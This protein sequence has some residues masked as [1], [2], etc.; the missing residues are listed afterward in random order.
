MRL[1]LFYFT[2]EVRESLTPD[3]F[4]LAF[5]SVNL[6]LRSGFG[7]NFLLMPGRS[8]VKLFD[9]WESQWFFLRASRT[10]LQHTGDLPRHSGVG[11]LK[12]APHPGEPRSTDLWKVIKIKEVSAERSFCDLMEEIVMAGRFMMRSRPRSELGIPRAFRPPQ[13]VIA[14]TFSEER[15]ARWAVQQIGPYGVLEHRGYETKISGGGC[16]NIIAKCFGKM[17]PWTRETGLR[18]RSDS[19]VELSTGASGAGVPVFSIGR[20]RLEVEAPTSGARVAVP[21]VPEGEPSTQARDGELPT[22]ED[23]VRDPLVTLELVR[24]LVE[25]LVEGTPQDSGGGAFRRFGRGDF[26]VYSCLERVGF[27]E[28]AAREAV[29]AELSRVSAE[30][31]AM[32]TKARLV[33]EHQAD[34]I[35]KTR[36]VEEDLVVANLDRE[37]ARAEAASLKVELAA[38]S[39]GPMLAP[40]AR[41]LRIVVPRWFR[42]YLL[43]P[44]RFGRR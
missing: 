30:L 32:E 14:P 5:G 36:R 26:Q 12:E 25:A 19:L 29:E 1:L 17:W 27:G 10:R 4:T 15:A 44:P 7:D 24:G 41:L 35:A 9:K 23:G 20:E 33:E 21:E 3:G 8:T 38:A 6:R 22:T 28:G 16:H 43:R 39:D 18:L 42:F 31:A 11:G 34:E 2:V 13:F 40:R 37:H